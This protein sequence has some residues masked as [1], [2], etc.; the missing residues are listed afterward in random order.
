MR[1]AVLRVLVGG[2]NARRVSSSLPE[3]RAMRQMGGNAMAAAW[4]WIPLSRLIEA[5]F[6][7]S[8]C[9]P[10]VLEAAQLSEAQ[11]KV[12]LGFRHT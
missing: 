8:G 7:R 3:L 2:C 5:L 4:R 6:R 1:M 11:G 9:C 10:D 12:G